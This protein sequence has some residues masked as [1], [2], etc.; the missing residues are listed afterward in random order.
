[1]EERLLHKGT[2]RLEGTRSL[3]EGLDPKYS[4]A[5]FF[6]EVML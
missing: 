2:A 3:M 1:M 5:P 4:T 6:H